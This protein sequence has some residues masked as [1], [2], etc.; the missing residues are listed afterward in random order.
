MHTHV[1]PIIESIE[2]HGA[3]DAFRALA[4]ADEAE[5]R[6]ARELVCRQADAV[7]I[8]LHDQRIALQT[9]VHAHRVGPRVARDVGQRFLHDAEDGRIAFATRRETFEL[10]VHVALTA[11]PVGELASLPFDR[12]FQAEVVED[13]GRSSAEM[14]WTV[15]RIVPASET[16]P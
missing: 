9:P 13:G 6:D 2:P 1:P 12:R 7:V 11:A 8:D 4:H 3:A 10:E 5:R 16:M 14:C 15:S